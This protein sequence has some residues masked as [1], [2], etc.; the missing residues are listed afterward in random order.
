MLAGIALPVFAAF[1][2]PAPDAYVSDHAGVISAGSEARMEAI[3]KQLDDA[4]QVQ[5][6]V[7]TVNSLGGE[8]VEMASLAV[9]REW[10]IGYGE[11]NR[12]LLILVAVDDRRM[13]TEVGY[14][15]EGVLPDG[16]TGEVRDRYMLPNFRRG[17]FDTGISTAFDAYAGRIAEAYDVTISET[18]GSGGAAASRRTSPRA[19]QQEYQPSGLFEM[20]ALL[21]LSGLIY[22]FPLLFVAVIVFNIVRGVGRGGRG[23][24]FYGG[25]YGGGGFGGGGFGGGGFG[26]FGGG[27]FGGG[28]SS[29]GW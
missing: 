6:A 23:G 7:L 10:G 26:G 21:M 18:S 1:K 25:F 16:Y 9:A 24:G 13:R 28:G 15:L 2:V 12:G 4:A 5:M 8:S 19:Y 17:D 11:S 22:L 20:L 3:A 29:G 14:G 27:G